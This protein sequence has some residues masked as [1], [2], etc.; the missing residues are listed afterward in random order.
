MDITAFIP[1]R[2]GSKGIH[3]KNIVDFHGYPLL[4][5]TIDVCKKSKFINKRLENLINNSILITIIQ[6]DLEIEFILYISKQ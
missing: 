4:K 1:A 5:H 3:K 2:G 6:Q